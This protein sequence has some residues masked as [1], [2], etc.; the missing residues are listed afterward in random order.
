MQ[1]WHFLV[2][3]RVN[4]A[5][6]IS[7]YQNRPTHTLARSF[8]LGMEPNNGA[9]YTSFAMLTCTLLQHR[10]RLYLVCMAWMY[11]IQAYILFKGVL[12]PRRMRHL[13]RHLH[14]GRPPLSDAHRRPCIDR[15]RKERGSV[16]R[17]KHRGELRIHAAL[18]TRTPIFWSQIVGRTENR[19]ESVKPGPHG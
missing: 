16:E 1:I 18:R 8:S 11:Y 2:C 14:R 3:S 9:H 6:Y 4:T 5:G 13:F 15:V 7:I 10:R 19:P 12:T 17:D